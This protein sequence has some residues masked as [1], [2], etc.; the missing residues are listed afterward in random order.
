MCR[1]LFSTPFYRPPSGEYSARRPGIK[2]GR[3][4][5]RFSEGHLSAANFGEPRYF[6][7]LTHELFSLL[8]YQIHAVLYMERYA[9]M[10]KGEK[11]SR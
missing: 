7:P 4:F 1:C 8:R 3:E 5:A 9:L 11:T 10:G 6:N 2:T